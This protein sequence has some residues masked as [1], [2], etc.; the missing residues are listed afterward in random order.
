MDFNWI[1]WIIVIVVLYNVYEGFEEGITKL[2]TDLLSFLGALWL[3][4]R[5]HSVVGSFIEQKFGISS[6]W[7]N[8]L[9][10]I[11]VGFLAELVLAQLLHKLVRLIPG[12][13]E[14]SR[15]D[16]GLGA[17]FSAL[18]ALIIITFVLLL[19]LALPLRGTVKTDIRESVIGGKLIKLPGKYVD[20]LNNTLD[21]QVTAALKFVT[22]KPKSTETIPLTELP[23]NCEY[24]IDREA[25]MEMLELVNMERIL[26]GKEAL[27]WD[28]DVAVVARRHS[29]DMF[30]RRYFAH[31]S[32]EGADVGTRLQEAEIDY[33]FAGEN[34]AFA[35]DVAVAHD[36]LMNSPGHKDNILE[37]KFERVGIGVYDGGTCGMMFTQNFVD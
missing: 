7:T 8:V 10:Y 11:V 1:D 34:L 6:L 36:G 19:I 35:P 31:Q 9:G 4:I 23:K 24:K 28:E 30:E 32:P 22:V 33:S 16:R 3:T 25:E 18:K 15:V 13:W 12:N 27:V 17:I 37:E 14:R 20:D 26:E 2:G 21:K 29:L 5:Y